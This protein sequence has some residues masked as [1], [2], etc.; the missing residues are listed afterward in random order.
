MEYEY[1]ALPLILSGSR[2]GP[3]NLET[4]LSRTRPLR[5]SEVSHYLP[6]GLDSCESRSLQ[7]LDI[8]PKNEANI[9][10]HP[11]WSTQICLRK[12]YWAGFGAAV[13]HTEEA[14]LQGAC[15]AYER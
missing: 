2:A 6:K 5:T 15:K 12:K 9:F 10:P 13:P 11:P 7:W 8:R 4:Q 14:Q 3:A 1:N